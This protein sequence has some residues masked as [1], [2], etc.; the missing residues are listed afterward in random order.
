MNLPKDE[1]QG[2]RAL[3]FANRTE[4]GLQPLLERNPAA[5]VNRNIANFP[6]NIGGEVRLKQGRNTSI[7]ERLVAFQT[8]V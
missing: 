5:K 4:K 7:I 6:P 1:N 3:Q 2:L 8:R